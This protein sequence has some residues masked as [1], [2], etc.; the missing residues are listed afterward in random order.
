MGLQS[1]RVGDHDDVY[2]H[3]AIGS[4]AISEHFLT[5]FDVVLT[6]QAQGDVQR[7]EV[8]VLP[9]LRVQVRLSH[10]EIIMDALEDMGGGSVE[11]EGKEGKEGKKEG[12]E[13]KED[14]A[15]KEAIETQDRKEE[16]IA[17]K[18]NT[19]ASLSPKR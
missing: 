6:Y 2:G 13:G 16:N 9:L 7:G 5:P 4:G 17:K 3:E 19:A 14:G 15:K 1:N 18:N 8:D 11:E 12:K 10:Y